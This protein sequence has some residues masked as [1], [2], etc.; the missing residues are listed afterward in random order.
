MSSELAIR[1]DQQ[2]WT[3]KQLAALHQLGVSDASDAD[4]GVFFHQATKSGLDPFAKQI[5]MIGRKSKRWDRDANREVWETKQTI[6]TGI[7]GFRL[8]ARRAVDKAHGTLGYEDT[9]FCGENGVWTSAWVSALP[10]VAAKV[11]VLRD[12]Q[13]FPAVALYREYVQTVSKGRD[14]P[15]E[16][17]NMWARMPA[18]Q[19]AKCAEALALRKAFPQDLSGLYTEDE[20]GQADG[21]MVAEQPPAETEQQR[22]ERRRKRMFAL[23][24]DLEIKS[25]EG[26]LAM[27]SEIVGRELESSKELSWPAEVERVISALEDVQREGPSSDEV[28][29]AEV[30]EGPLV[31]EGVNPVTG[32][33]QGD[34]WA[35]GPEGDRA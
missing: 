12:G 31:P 2:G 25:R 34:P 19:L 3:D 21:Q 22:E 28:V 7:D 4:L 15:P 26:M 35:K 20:M 13:P 29:D 32:E 10:P 14:K 16:P 30:I 17:N 1:D 24:G 8:I 11:T 9:L 27:A 23:F 18:N 6:Q 5:Y 33:V